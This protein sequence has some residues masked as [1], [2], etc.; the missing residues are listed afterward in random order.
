MSIVLMHGKGRTMN[1]VVQIFIQNAA[2]TIQIIKKRKEITVTQIL[3]LMKMRKK[4]FVLAQYVLRQKRNTAEVLWGLELASTH[5]RSILEIVL[6][7]NTLKAQ[8]LL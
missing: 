6:K 3:F 4:V 5:K 8:I 7:G 1:E 2:L